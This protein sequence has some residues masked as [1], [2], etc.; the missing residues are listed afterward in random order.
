MF[1]FLTFLFNFTLFLL[2][3]NLFSPLFVHHCYTSLQ[4]F[5]CNPQVH[6]TRPHMF[7][8][9]FINFFKPCIHL[10]FIN[11]N[12]FFTHSPITPI[13]QLLHHSKPI[14]LMIFNLPLQEKFNQSINF[15]HIFILVFVHL[16]FPR[17]IF[18]HFIPFMLQPCRPKT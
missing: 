16:I 8:L 10:H 15:L 11:Y 1:P 13:P 12:V 18:P 2:L 17:L 3:T 7:Q 9:L 6:R 4:L 5:L 14:P